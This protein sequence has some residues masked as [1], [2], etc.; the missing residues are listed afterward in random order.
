MGAAYLSTH[1]FATLVA[2][3]RVNGGGISGH[4][5][6]ELRQGDVAAAAAAP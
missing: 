6:A 2:M 3:E 1:G 4:L 5:P